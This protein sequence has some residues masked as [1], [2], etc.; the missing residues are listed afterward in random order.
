M[1]CSARELDLGDDH[2]GILV[3][4]TMGFGDDEGARPG[5]DAIALLGLGEEVLEI[6]VTP[7][8]GYCF[9]LRGVAREYA[10]ATGGGFRDPA[11][12]ELPPSDGP[13]FAVRLEDAAPLRGRVGCDRYVA[14]I[15]RGVDASRPSPYWMQRRLR[16][17]G[18][19]ADLARCRRHQ[20]RDACHRTTV[21]RVRPGPG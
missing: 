7:D 4:A 16:Q 13:G 5:A 18:M 20:L 6:N 21:A 9:S 3:L 19:R 12:V 8:R 2:A 1:I 17:A 10:T 14:R 15:V 11:A